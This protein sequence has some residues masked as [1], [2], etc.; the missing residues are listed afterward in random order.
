MRIVITNWFLFFILLREYLCIVS[1][2]V[3][4]I[5]IFRSEISSKQWTD[6]FKYFQMNFIERDI[7]LEKQ[8][9]RMSER[10]IRICISIINHYSYVLFWHVIVVIIKHFRN[11]VFKELL[12]Q[13]LSFEGIAKIY[14]TLVA[15]FIIICDFLFFGT[16]FIII[17]ILLLLSQRSFSLRLNVFI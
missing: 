14:A 6:F 4:R 3:L 10:W 1:L 12:F 17:L 2:K 15:V 9:S 7:S 5:H 11:V 16:I 8:Y 13:S